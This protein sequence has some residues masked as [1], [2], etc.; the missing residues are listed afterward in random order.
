[1]RRLRVLYLFVMRLHVV[2]TLVLAKLLK[3]CCKVGSI[4]PLYSKMH[5]SFVRRA[6]DAKW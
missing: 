5:L 3:K 6:I 1:M 4:G 2:D